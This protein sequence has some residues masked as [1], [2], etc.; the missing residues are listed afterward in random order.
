MRLIGYV[1]WRMLAVPGKIPLTGASC[2]LQVVAS[3]PYID[4]PGKA[5]KTPKL[6]NHIQFSGL[7]SEAP[8]PW[9]LGSLIR[10]LISFG[11]GAVPLPSA[12]SRGWLFAPQLGGTPEAL[13]LM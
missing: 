3:R 5:A 4:S 11:R 10:G 7:S 6:P 8:L 13:A 12:R 2:T 9:K 1:N